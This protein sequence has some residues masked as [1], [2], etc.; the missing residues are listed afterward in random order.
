MKQLL[1]MMALIVPVYADAVLVW[2]G[3]PTVVASNPS[4]PPNVSGGQGI[5]TTNFCEDPN[6]PSCDIIGWTADRT[7]TVTSPGLFLLSSSVGISESANNCSPGGCRPFAGLLVSF[8]ESDSI[9][10]PVSFSQSL[11]DSGQIGPIFPGG[12]TSG[13]CASGTSCSAPPCSAEF[14]ILFC[15]VVIGRTES[16]GN[17]VDLSPGDYKLEQ[18]FFYS[19]ESN[20]DDSGRVSVTTDLVAAIPE[21]GAYAPVLICGLAVFV[22]LKTKGGFSC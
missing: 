6:V 16:Q 17:T 5:F 2:T 19:S 3:D 14:G 9:S 12:S 7:F 11:S 15:V 20:G 21:P 1:I 8:T 13:F 10:G 4:F 18:T 22:W